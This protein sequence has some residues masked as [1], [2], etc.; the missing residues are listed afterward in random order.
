MSKGRV[1]PLKVLALRAIEREIKEEEVI[2]D[3]K[4]LLEFDWKWWLG[5][6]TYLRALGLGQPKERVYRELFMS[7]FPGVDPLKIS[8]S[9]V[10]RSVC[11]LPIKKM[12][13]F[14]G[15]AVHYDRVDVLDDLMSDLRLWYPLRAVAESAE[16]DSDGKEK[17]LG[18]TTQYYACHIYSSVPPL[19][20]VLMS[21]ICGKRD[22]WDKEEVRIYLEEIEDM[23][24]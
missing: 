13:T 19:D 3:L 14:M 6:P 11:E 23:K 9:K 4:P 17:V 7:T 21:P 24:G 15:F 1:L 5:L 22:L 12:M 10:A 20:S 18:N 16:R 8:K 2:D